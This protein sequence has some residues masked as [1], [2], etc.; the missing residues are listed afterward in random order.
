LGP[1][2]N[3]SQ[4]IAGPGYW[5]G[6]HLHKAGSDYN[7]IDYGLMEDF[8]VIS[9]YP[10]QLNKQLYRFSGSK[11]AMHIPNVTRELDSS[12]GTSTRTGWHEIN[13]RWQVWHKK[14]GKGQN[15]VHLHHH[16]NKEMMIFVIRE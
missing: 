2:Y 9:S 3:L 12:R 14:R 16:L 11:Q 13:K 5:D 10:E 8:T 6:V 15:Q 4:G 1:H 7:L